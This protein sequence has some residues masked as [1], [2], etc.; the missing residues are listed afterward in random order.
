MKS[1]SFN[2]NAKGFSLIE[3]LLV[4]G[5]LAIL[6]VAAFVVYPQVRDRNQA[7]AEVAN[8]TSI[9]ANLNNLYAPRGGNYTGLDTGVA[10]EARVFPS[11][12]NGGVYGSTT[13]INSSWG[14]PVTVVVGTATTA[15][16]TP[17]SAIPANRNFRITYN[18]VP[19]GV[20]L[21]LVSGAATNFQGVTVGSTN[22]MTTTG[23]DPG[24]AASACN[25]TDPDVVFISN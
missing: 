11:S 20:C 5:V 18:D 3:L 10:N 19:T 13:T 17:P 24:A 9:K 8:L 1:F 21:G 22:V 23:F 16:Q 7:N 2:R 4:L 12:M 15:A 25:T 14:K 6:L